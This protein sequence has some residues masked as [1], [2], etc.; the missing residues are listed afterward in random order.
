M[1]HKIR[2]IFKMH[3]IWVENRKRV[4]YWRYL[5]VWRPHIY[6]PLGNRSAVLFIE[7]KACPTYSL[8]CDP[9]G[10]LFSSDISVTFYVMSM[11]NHH[12]R[13]NNLL[14]R[15]NIKSHTNIWLY[16]TVI[17]MIFSESVTFLCSINLFLVCIKIL[18]YNFILDICDVTYYHICFIRVGLSYL[19]YF[20]S[21]ILIYGQS[22]SK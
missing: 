16:T 6:I 3:V 19:I 7:H 13:N 12:I 5:W 22:E 20:A 1:Y 21:K 8:I 9:F 17:S 18:K 10:S 4:R 2:I 14:K 11:L 15:P